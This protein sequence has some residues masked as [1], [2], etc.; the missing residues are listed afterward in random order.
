MVKDSLIS[1]G[2]GRGNFTYFVIGW[3]SDILVLHDWIQT[4][5]LRLFILFPL[6]VGCNIITEGALRAD[7]NC[8]I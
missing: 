5:L 4:Y 1:M 7:E 8:L 6:Y 3:H 2:D